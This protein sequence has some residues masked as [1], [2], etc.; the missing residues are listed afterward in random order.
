MSTSLLPIS[1]VHETLFRGIYDA[2]DNSWDKVETLTTKK[3]ACTSTLISFCQRPCQARARSLN[4]EHQSRQET[5]EPS[6]SKRHFKFII[7]YA[8]IVAVLYFTAKLFILREQIMIDEYQNDIEKLEGKFTV[9]LSS[10]LSQLRT[11]LRTQIGQSLVNT[12]K[13]AEVSL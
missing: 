11:Q 9:G 4:A 10:T 6:D 2:I 1:L 3:T 8:S 12:P 7:S 13:P 5:T